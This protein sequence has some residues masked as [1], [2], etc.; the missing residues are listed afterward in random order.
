MNR[1]IRDY[2]II[3]NTQSAALVSSHASIDWCCLPRFD[4]PAF[5]LRILDDER[6]GYCSVS[7]L[8]ESKVSRAY[9]Q[10]TNVLR[11]TLSQ[12]GGELTV[13]D[14]MPVRPSDDRRPKGQDVEA[15]SQIIRLLRCTGGAVECTIE[16]RP[17]FGNASEHARIAYD[18]GLL[19]F[20]ANSQKLHVQLGGHPE[21]HDDKISSVV[22]LEKGETVAVVLTHS[23]E[24]PAA[25][26]SGAVDEALATTQEYWQLWAEKSSYNGKYREAV[27]R[28]ALVLKLLT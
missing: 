10:N 15:K 8:G 17:T 14:F 21:I 4:S 11:T 24:P 20:R 7:P 16:I 3:G 26:A 12:P 23:D 6:G 9:V 28:S 18:G 22:R 27:I 25:L 1:R 13:T 2:A 5:F 19:T